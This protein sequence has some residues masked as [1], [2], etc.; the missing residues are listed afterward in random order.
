MCV[1]DNLVKV[2]ILVLRPSP[3]SVFDCLQYV[4]TE[5]KVLGFCYHVIC[6]TDV[7]TGLRC[8]DIFNVIFSL[9]R[10]QGNKTSSSQETSSTSNGSE[11]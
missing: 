11:A 4:K 7:I 2:D 1:V 8:R 6:S 3:L 10:S 5:G 9:Q